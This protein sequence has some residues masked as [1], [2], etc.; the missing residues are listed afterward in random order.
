M[1]KHSIFNRRIKKP[2]APA[3]HPMWSGIG[4]ILAILVPGLSLIATN[5]LINN[6]GSVNW[7]A[8]PTEMILPNNQDPMILIRILYTALFSLVIFFLISIITFIL[9]SIFNPKR[10]GPFDV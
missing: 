5:I 7:L 1:P 10:K 4:C 8:I 9:D 3:I 2:K 6:Q